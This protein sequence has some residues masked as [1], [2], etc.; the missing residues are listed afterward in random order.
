M[1]RTALIQLQASS[2]KQQN[3]ERT[4]EKVAEAA[5]AGAQLI[6]LQELF[7]TPYFCQVQDPTWLDT[8]EAIDGPLCKMVAAAA[9]QLK[10]VIVAP[11]FEKRAPGLYHNSVVV[12]GPDGAQLAHYRKSHIPDD[13]QFFEK[14]YFAPGDTG[15]VTCKVSTPAPVNI[16]PLICW[17]QWFPEAARVSALRGAEVLI[18]PT[19]IGWMPEEKAEYGAAQLSAW[20]TVQ[21]SHAIT[22]GVYVLAV[23]RV[24]FEPLPGSTQGQGIEFWGHSFVCDPFGE[25]IAEAGEEEQT[26]IVDCDLGRV[27]HARRTWPFLRDRRVDLYGDLSR[28]YADKT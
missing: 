15:F 13:P 5:R 10:V 23:N 8:A 25:V 19:A 21:R 14:Y 2:D 20:Q 3:S 4:L 11:V 27:E 18:Y 17:D 7:A 24:G 28:Q 12:V 22:N 9:R 6:C 1:L 26:L 16:A